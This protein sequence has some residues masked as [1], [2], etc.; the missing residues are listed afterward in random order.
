M[1]TAEAYD[2]LL[3]HLLLSRCKI[4]L[5]L[6]LLSEIVLLKAEPLFCS[7]CLHS[8]H[9]N[10]LVYSNICGEGLKS[11]SKL[12]LVSFMV[13]TSN[14]FQRTS[15]RSVEKLSHDKLLRVLLF[16]F[17]FF[18][19]HSLICQDKFY[20]FYHFSFMPYLG[21]LDGINCVN[22]VRPLKGKICSS[23]F[24]FSRGLSF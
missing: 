20:L 4:M 16:L 13:P 8:P 15:A 12:I 21:D 24:I 18:P 1:N 17:G 7:F 5:G 2:P 14:N 23:T 3:R 11:D 10:M 9:P 6:L 19:C 22:L